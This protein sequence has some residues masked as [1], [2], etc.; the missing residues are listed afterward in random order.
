MEYITSFTLATFNTKSSEPAHLQLKEKD[1][2]EE[3]HS[4]TWVQPCGAPAPGDFRPTATS[5]PLLESI[6]GLA[7]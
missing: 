6:L 3:H 7:L 4:I 2:L 1:V 5:A